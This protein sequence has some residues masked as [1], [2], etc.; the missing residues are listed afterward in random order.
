[1]GSWS[2]ERIFDL[3]VD[4]LLLTI[5]LLHMK[6]RF[7]VVN[8]QPFRL[9]Y[10]LDY[11]FTLQVEFLAL[12][13]HVPIV[14]SNHF[15]PGVN[16]MLH[17]LM[18]YLILSQRVKLSIDRLVKRP[19]SVLTATIVVI[20]SIVQNRHLEIMVDLWQKRRVVVRD[21]QRMGNHP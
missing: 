4:K 15:V 3:N 17:M 12:S 11:L 13:L 2:Y 14:S 18:F 5:L 21:H 8:P 20:A 1:M 6:L 16:L 10:I 9:A 19:Y 7:A